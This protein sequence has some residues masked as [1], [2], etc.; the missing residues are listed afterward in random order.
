MLTTA[1]FELLQQFYRAA[2]IS[3]V[4]NAVS[5]CADQP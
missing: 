1:V 5:S 2:E 3:N 4:A